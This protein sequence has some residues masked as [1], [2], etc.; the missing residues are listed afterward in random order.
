MT[1]EMIDNFRDFYNYDRMF[2]RYLTKYGFKY[3]DRTQILVENMIVFGT[4]TFGYKWSANPEYTVS[5]HHNAMTWDMDSW[6]NHTKKEY[7]FDRLGLLRLYKVF[8]RFK[9]QIWNR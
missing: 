8:K 5:F 4:G 6:D 2:A 1:Q 3:V 9:N 7:M